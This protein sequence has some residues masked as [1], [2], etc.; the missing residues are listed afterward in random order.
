VFDAFWSRPAYLHQT[1][2][3][4]RLAMA[5]VTPTEASER[6][7]EIVDATE[8]TLLTRAHR[9][10]ERNTALVR[11][12]KELALATDGHLRCEV[13]AFDFAERYG[14]RGAGFIERHHTVPLSEAKSPRRTK[15]DDLALICANCH[16]MIH[17][18]RPWLSL[19]QLRDLLC[20]HAA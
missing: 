18:S 19:D 13:C 7:P 3:A 1:A 6:E 15:L 20:E 2:Q 11:R 8:G 14:E 17:R 9:S 12:R 4:I 5:A 10:R 16:R